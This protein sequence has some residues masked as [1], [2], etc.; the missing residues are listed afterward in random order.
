MRVL[1]SLFDTEKKYIENICLKEQKENIEP[2]G[3]ILQIQQLLLH[4]YIL[5]HYENRYE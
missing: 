5:K 1:I 2:V 3:S 4:N